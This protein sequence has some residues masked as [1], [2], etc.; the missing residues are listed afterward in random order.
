MT[1]NNAL[2]TPKIAYTYSTYIHHTVHT[3]Y[4]RT[5]C[6]SRS[7][8][9][10]RSWPQPSIHSPSLGT[11][12]PYRWPSQTALLGHAH[13]QHPAIPSELSTHTYTNIHICIHI[14][15]HTHTHT[16]T[17]MYTHTY[18]HTYI[19]T[20]IHIHTHTYTYISARGSRSG[21][22]NYYASANGRESWLPT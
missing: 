16:Y 6:P 8:L 2:V 13:Q 3:L 10:C 7:S 22:V 17:H 4:V 9:C 18:T 19:Y 12:L 11:R 21:H 5:L 1:R 15:I 14:H 20:H